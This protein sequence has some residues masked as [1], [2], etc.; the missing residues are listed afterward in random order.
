MS[1]GLGHH[2]KKLES[3]EKRLVLQRKIAEKLIERRA[4]ANDL[5]VKVEKERRQMNALL[6]VLNAK[7]DRIIG[8]SSTFAYEW[9][10]KSHLNYYSNV[11]KRIPT[12]E[13]GIRPH[14]NV[15]NKNSNVKKTIK[16]IFLTREKS[17]LH[18]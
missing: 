14:L 1:E 13:Y 7:L 3:K 8:L 9:K 4:E 11:I 17:K 2:K 6:K 5:E 10:I 16:V 15:T 18:F 12:H